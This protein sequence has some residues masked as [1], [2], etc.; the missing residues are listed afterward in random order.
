MVL[1]EQFEMFLSLRTHDTF[2]V[3]IPLIFFAY[4]EFRNFSPYDDF[5]QN[6]LFGALEYSSVVLKIAARS[7]HFHE[8]GH[9]SFPG[10]F[11]TTFRKRAI[12]RDVA[13]PPGRGVGGL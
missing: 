3:E 6:G 1:L 7:K 2:H 8:A 9:D 13:F 4:G 5:F 12:L 11:E 10:K